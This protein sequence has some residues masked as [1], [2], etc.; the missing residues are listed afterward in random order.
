MKIHTVGKAKKLKILYIETCF[1][2][3]NMALAQHI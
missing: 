3:I 1:K 2:S